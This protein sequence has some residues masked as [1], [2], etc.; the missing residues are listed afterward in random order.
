M[1]IAKIHKIELSGKAEHELSAYAY[2]RAQEWL[3]EKLYPNKL[4]MASSNAEAARKFQ[5]HE[6]N[7]WLPSWVVTCGVTMKHFVFE[8]KFCEV[9]ENG[10]FWGPDQMIGC[11]SGAPA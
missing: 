10:F 2:R 8:M 3:S 5:L 1:I 11:Y 4:V 9:D 7:T 6:L